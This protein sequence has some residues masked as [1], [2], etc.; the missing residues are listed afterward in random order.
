M[1]VQ[2]ADVVRALAGREKDDIF[3]VLDVAEGYALLADGRGRK[4]E[5]PKRKKLKH[6]QFLSRTDTRVTRKLRA[7]ERVL[8]SELRRE[9]TELGQQFSQ[10]QGG[11]C[12]WQKTT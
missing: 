1:E 9:L 12:S 6:V 4:Q 2:K 11:S 10:N 8:N 7:G 3:F 5:K